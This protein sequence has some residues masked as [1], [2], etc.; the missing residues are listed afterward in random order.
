[1]ELFYELLL[2]AA[3]SLLVAFLLAASSPI[4]LSSK[5]TKN[6]ILHVRE[7][8][9]LPHSYPLSNQIDQSHA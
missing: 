1:M 4:D 5:N 8:M 3:A 9:M 2:T 6:R 7:H